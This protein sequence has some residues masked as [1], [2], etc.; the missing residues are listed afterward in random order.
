MKGGPKPTTGA[1]SRILSTGLYLNSSYILLANVSIY[2]SRL[3][4][5]SF[6]G[7]IFKKESSG[8]PQ[9]YVSIG[10]VYTLTAV[11]NGKTLLTKKLPVLK[12]SVVDIYKKKEPQALQKN[13]TEL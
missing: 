9:L 6:I 1:L 3:K 4:K 10:I 5:S 12:H 8:P 13:N 11:H 2:N 7:H